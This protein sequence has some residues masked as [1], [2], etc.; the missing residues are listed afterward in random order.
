MNKNG[1]RYTFSNM[2]YKMCDHPDTHSVV[3]DGQS[4]C[5]KCGL[6]MKQII[7]D[8][9]EWRYYGADDRNDD[10]CRT[11]AVNNTLLPDSSYGSVA[12]NIKNSSPHFRQIAKLSAWAMASHSDRS[13]LAAIDIL[14]TYAYRTGLPKAILA[15]ACSLLRSQEDALK[16]RGETRR[17]LMGAVFFVACRRNDVS[18]THEEIADMVK[19]STRSLCKGIQRFDINISNSENPLLQTQLSLAE[20][21][22]NGLSLSEEQRSKIVSAIRNVF[23]NPDEELEHTPKVMVA[24]TIASIIVKDTT[25]PKNIVKQFSK[26]CGV[27]VVSIQK[28]MGKV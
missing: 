25:D 18:R 16:L 22:M 3:E 11:G 10:P 1:L 24:G 26:H 12:M 27:S 5:S 6:I 21:M 13:W 23:K 9:P 19:V 14:Q 8:G 20:R 17:A 15:E 7:D 28:V 2:Y 4:V